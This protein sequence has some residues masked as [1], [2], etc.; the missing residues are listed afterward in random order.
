MSKEA[1]LEKLH[2]DYV[3]LG[4]AKTIVRAQVKAEFEAKIRVEVKKR[5]AEAEAE[6]ARNLA[7][8]KERYGLTVTAIQDEVLGSRTWSRW[9]KWRDLMG[10]EPERKTAEGARA[11]KRG[12]EKPYRIEDGKVIVTRNEH[13]PIEEFTLI[14]VGWNEPE[15]K[16]VSWPPMAPGEPGQE[17]YRENFEGVS[18]LTNFLNAAYTEYGDTPEEY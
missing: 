9:E 18:H 13:G 8:A 16:F 15:Q 7:D 10:I 3:S 6:F 2:S 11:A 12:A 1:V 4:A 17:S 14:G 5:V